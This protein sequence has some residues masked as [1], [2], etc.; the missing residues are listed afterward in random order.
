MKPHQLFVILCLCQANLAQAE[1]YKRVDSKGHVTYSS[2]PLK[3][4]RKLEL[5]PLPTM[6]GMRAPQRTPED[7]PKVDSQTQKSRDATRRLILEDELASEEK[8]LAAARENLTSIENNPEPLI[9]PDGIPFRNTAR[10]AEK[11]KAAQEAV[12][13]HE[14]NIKALKTEISNLK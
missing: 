10:Q 13:L 6:P 2:E 14:Q 12:A 9:G 8:L 7:F 4:G 1:I 5:K 11:V 3:G